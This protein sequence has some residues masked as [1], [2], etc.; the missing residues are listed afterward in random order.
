MDILETLD[1]SNALEILDLNFE[2]SK[3]GELLE[4]MNL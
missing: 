2:S 4:Q 3:E 1:I